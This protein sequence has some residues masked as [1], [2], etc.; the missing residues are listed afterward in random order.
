M[1][2]KISKEFKNTGV[3]ATYWKVA[4]DN[5]TIKSAKT[6]PLKNPQ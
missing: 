6:Y 4:K 3:F 1:A 2:L 5:V